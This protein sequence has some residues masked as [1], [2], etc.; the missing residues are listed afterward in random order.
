MHV[1]KAPRARVRRC[2]IH[3]IHDVQILVCV[4]KMFGQRVFPC[5]CDQSVNGVP[6]KE[7][8]VKEPLA[9]FSPLAGQ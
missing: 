5:L 1:E 4:P 3:G 7:Y 9:P 6:H 8:G 2:L